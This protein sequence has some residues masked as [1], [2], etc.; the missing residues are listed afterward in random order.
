L[1]RWGGATK[2]QAEALVVGLE[3][4]LTLMLLYLITIE[5]RR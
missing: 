2:V 3:S 4:A 1:Y 5:E